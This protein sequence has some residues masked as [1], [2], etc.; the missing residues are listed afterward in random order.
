[1]KKK[2]W[3]LLLVSH[4]FATEV[5]FNSE[6]NLKNGLYP[7]SLSEITNRIDSAADKKKLHFAIDYTAARKNVI[8]Q[9]KKPLLNLLSYEVYKT[10]K[11]TVYQPKTPRVLN[12]LTIALNGQMVEF[13]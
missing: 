12:H 6:D 5:I 11:L 8:E 4:L 3:L 9:R 7:Y 10:D 1:M 2:F 13:S